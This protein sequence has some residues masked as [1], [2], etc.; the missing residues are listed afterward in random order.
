MT[1]VLPRKFHRSRSALARVLAV[2]NWRPPPGI[3]SSLYVMPSHRVY[4]VLTYGDTFRTVLIRKS[5][6]GCIRMQLDDR[7]MELLISA[8]DPLTPL[9]RFR[10]EMD[11]VDAS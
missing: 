1:N 6:P 7:S 11:D 5:C 9:E 2:A 10:M 4:V 8:D 3:R